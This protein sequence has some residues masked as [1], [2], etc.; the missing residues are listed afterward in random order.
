V[1]DTR[2]LK[3]A[4]LLLADGQLDRV[5]ELLHDIEACDPAPLRDLVLGSYA[6]EAGD[7]DSAQRLLSAAATRRPTTSLSA[8]SSPEPCADPNQTKTPTPSGTIEVG[9]QTQCVPGGL[10]QHWPT[11]CSTVETEG[12]RRQG[13]QRGLHGS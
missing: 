4:R 5:A 11:D 13:P 10:S 6:Y 8:E 2:L 1:A 9:Y 7:A 12:W 3:G